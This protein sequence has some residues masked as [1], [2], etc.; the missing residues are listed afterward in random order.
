MLDLLVP[1]YH[2]EQGMGSTCEKAVTFLFLSLLVWLPFL[3]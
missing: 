1:L 2:R 3:G